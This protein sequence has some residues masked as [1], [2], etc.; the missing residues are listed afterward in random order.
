[1]AT[2]SDQWYKAAIDTIVI[3]EVLKPPTDAYGFQ[4]AEAEGAYLVVMSTRFQPTHGTGELGTSAGARK[5]RIVDASGAVLGQLLEEV[6]ANPNG[7]TQFSV[8]DIVRPDPSK[9][10]HVELQSY[11]DIGVT[12]DLRYLSIIRVGSGPAGSAG[13]VGPVGATGPQ[14]PTGP[15][16]NASSGYATYDGLT[17]G[18]DSSVAPAFG[19]GTDW[20]RTADQQLPIPR[21]NEKPSTPWFMQL[22][23]TGLEHRLVRRYT[24]AAD[25]A[26]RRGTIATGDMT[27]MTDTG[28]LQFREKNGNELDVARVHV[29]SAAAPSGSG[30]AAPGVLWIQI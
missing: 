27:V 28:Q 7:I 1:V 5:A 13:P 20:L 10:Y 15:A 14:G 26:T 8:V 9:I 19:S 29:D 23:A 11:D 22:L 30:Q 17:G 3:N 4:F 24:S 25:R 18:T 6:A 21:H 2:A 12:N 16:G